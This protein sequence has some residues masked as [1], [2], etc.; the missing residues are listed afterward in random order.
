MLSIKNHH[1]EKLIKLYRR[2]EPEVREKILELMEFEAKSSKRNRENR[3]HRE[4][5]NAGS[6]IIKNLEAYLRGDYIVLTKGD[7]DEYFVK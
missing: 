4:V 3:S 2:F 1:E 5:S 7:L 6:R